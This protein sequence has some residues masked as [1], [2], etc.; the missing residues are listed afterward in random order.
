MDYKDMSKGYIT[1]NSKRNLLPNQNGDRPTGE[2]AE[3]VFEKNQRLLE[4]FHRLY[5]SLQDVRNERE[6]NKRYYFGDQ[7]GD[8]I[9]D[10]Q[11][12]NREITEREYYARQGI[13]PLT[14]NVIRKVGKAIVGVYRQEKLE[15]LAVARDRDEQKLGE[16][17]SVALQYA[18]QQNNLDETNARGY[19]EFLISAI[20]CFRIGYEWD[21]SREVSD[22][23]VS[24]CDINRM[25]WDDNTTGQYFENIS[26]IGYLHDFTLGAVLAK[27][28]KTRGEKE[29]IIQIYQHCTNNTDYYTQQLQQ[30]NR[31]SNIDFYNPLN[32]NQCR[33]I[34]IWCKEEYDSYIC[35]DTAKGELFSIDI[36]EEEYITAA[37]QKR[38]A[39]V[40]S[41]GGS[42][43]DAQLIEYEYKVNERWVVRYLTPNGYVLHQS[44]TPYWHGSHPFAIGAYPL[45][46]GEVHSLINDTI[47]PQRMINR[48]IIR[49]EF[50][51]MN[52]AKGFGIINKKV[53]DKSGISEAQFANAYTS[54]D[55]IIALEFEDGTN[56][57]IRY[58]DVGGSQSDSEMLIKYFDILDQMSGTHGAMRGEV[59]KSGTPASLY[60]QEAQNANNNILDGQ[61]WY[62]GLIRIR[63]YKMMMVMQQYYDDVRY[64]NI[65]GHDYEEESKWYNP[66]KV[67]NSKFDLQLIQSTSSGITRALNEELLTQLLTQGAIDPISYL[68]S[69]SAPFADKLLSKLKSRQAEQA[70]QAQQAQAMPQEPMQNTLPTQQDYL[71]QLQ[72]QQSEIPNLQQV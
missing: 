36:N 24:L 6:R 54:P 34:E 5:Q 42:P 45:I 4:Y 65:A 50:I 38:I 7:L 21:S 12:P 31:K 30:D 14:M 61:A 13:M 37:N 53:L 57:F 72:Q 29:Q 19:E 11:C 23:K 49:T 62:N 39:D 26:C 41:A 32:P 8:T 63:D 59:A 52:E 3:R 44:V 35:H 68:E 25:A 55:A 20:P 10:P 46:D 1:P 16:M 70:Q 22:V 28:A 67:R 51:R 58:S 2:Q 17:M 33:V 48:I 15:P 18:Y 64:L 60:A 69:T 27:F 43:D 9:K 47:N 66:D 71:S 40:I 56:P